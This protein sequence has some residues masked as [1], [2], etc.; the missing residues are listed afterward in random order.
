MYVCIYISDNKGGNKKSLTEAITKPTTIKI[1][2]SSDSKKSLIKLFAGI[3]IGKP[4]KKK[5]QKKR[6]RRKKR[7]QNLKIIN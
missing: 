4:K 6:R 3:K 2:I 1:Y 7:Q 5:K